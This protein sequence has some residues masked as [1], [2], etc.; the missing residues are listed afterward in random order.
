MYLLELVANASQNKDL[1]EKA[2]SPSLKL[3]FKS[4]AG[5]FPEGFAP[6]HQ[7]LKSAK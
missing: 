4:M 6:Q 1:T 3:P 7:I 2:R 5:R